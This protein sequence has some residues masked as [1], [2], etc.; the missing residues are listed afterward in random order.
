MINVGMDFKEIVKGRGKIWLIL[1]MINRR[2][3]FKEIV[4]REAQVCFILNLYL[5]INKCCDGF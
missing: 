4:W 5:L 3:D 2:M 1:I